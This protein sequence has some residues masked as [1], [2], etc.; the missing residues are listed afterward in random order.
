[1]RYRNDVGFSFERCSAEESLVFWERNS[2]GGAFNNPSFL[3]I[4]APRVDWWRLAKGAE[5]FAMWPVPLDKSGNMYSPGFTYFV[6]PFWSNVALSRP[7]SSRFTDL[8]AGFEFCVPILIQNYGDLRFELSPTDWDVRFFSWWNYGNDERPKFSIEP[9]YS[10]RLS[11]LQDSSK[12]DLLA[13]FRE[14]RRREIRKVSS[15]GDFESDTQAGWLEIEDLYGQVLNRQA[16]LGVVD[17]KQSL[18]PVKILH[19]K[20]LLKIVANRLS[21]GGALASVAVLLE[22]K[23]EAH[24]LIN[25]TATEYLKSSV[26]TKTVFDAILRSREAGADVFDFNGANS[27]NRGSDKHSYGAQPLLFFRISYQ[28]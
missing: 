6:G 10:A 28:V 21:A 2:E 11:G 23:G 5:T 25:A 17:V 27:P 3:E 18:E 22:A 24:L 8:L 14:L 19:E 7:V 15:S 16:G 12:E 9:R 4:V 26:A 1:M 13:G 20:G